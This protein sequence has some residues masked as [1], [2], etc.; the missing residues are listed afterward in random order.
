MIR[1]SVAS[2]QEMVPID[3]AR[4]RNVVRTVLEG[5]GRTEAEI[6]LAFVDNPTSQRLNLQY[7][8]H[9]EPTD[10]LSF[11]LSE[12]KAGHLKGELVI[13]AEMAQ[14]QALERGHDVQA[15]LALYVIHGLLHFCG[16]DDQDSKSTLKMR[17][18]ERY[19]LK[20]LG[21]PAIA[22]E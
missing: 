5:E 19:F 15:E 16:Y 3:R 20:L 12:G 1:I 17:V 9:D 22:P 13:S 4:L 7:L 21:L 14:S 10:V 8:Q 18:R 11:P 2:P 6:S